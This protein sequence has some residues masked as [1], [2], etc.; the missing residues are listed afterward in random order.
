MATATKSLHLTLLRRF[1][2]D[3]A[4]SM[5]AY[6]SIQWVGCMTKLMSS[7]QRKHRRLPADSCWKAV[8]KD[9]FGTP[10]GTGDGIPSLERHHPR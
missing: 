9:R 4:I 10:D 8:R 2:Y 6:I 5:D 3:R 1:Q 7:A